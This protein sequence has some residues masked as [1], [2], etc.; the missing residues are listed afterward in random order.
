MDILSRITII[1][2]LLLTSP[3]VQ[4]H[5]LREGEWEGSVR[6]HEQAEK[7]AKFRV[8]HSGSGS[9]ITMFYNSRP[10][11]FKNLVVRAGKMTFDLDT[12][13]DY[14]C[15]LQRLSDDGF[16][17]KCSLEAGEEKR[18]IEINMHLPEAIEAEVEPEVQSEVEAAEVDEA[19]GEEQAGTKAEADEEPEAEKE[20]DG[21]TL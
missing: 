19:D 17:G 2:G 18:T 14:R 20:S 13:S 1:A 3:L 15:E 9:K 8:R 11:K 21:G 10:Y 5:E 7:I 6:M 16:A 4:A 12:G